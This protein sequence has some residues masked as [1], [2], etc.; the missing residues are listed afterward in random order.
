MEE[1]KGL[2]D[3]FPPIRKAEWLAQ[4]ER[5]LKGRPLEDLNWALEEGL[6]FSPFHHPEDLPE[7]PPPLTNLPKDK[8]GWQLVETFRLDGGFAEESLEAALGHGAQEVRWVF[9]QGC[10]LHE[11]GKGLERALNRTPFPC[12]FEFAQ[13][14]DSWFD[15]MADWAFLGSLEGSLLLPKEFAGWQDVHA[16]APRMQVFTVDLRDGARAGTPPSKELARALQKTV[17]WL[18]M[19]ERLGWSLEESL[20]RVRFLMSMG[21]DYLAGIAELRALRLLWFNL[22]ESLECPH[23]I[24]PTVEVQV[25]PLPDTPDPNHYLIE[26]TTRTMAAVLGGAQAVGILP[27]ED[28]LQQRR[29]C[30]NLHHILRLESK[31]ERVADPAAGSFF[32]E[33]LTERLAEKVWKDLGKES[34]A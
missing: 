28:T 19:G 7:P 25:Y 27:A 20:S 22:L 18:E 31:L 26:A 16:L 32:F 21:R 33:T 1:A 4:V 15:R 6:V 23:P 17:R 2:F 9:G 13:A 34:P 29:L 11:V 10:D 5:E 30:R 3:E 14:E 12:H 24:S 8:Q